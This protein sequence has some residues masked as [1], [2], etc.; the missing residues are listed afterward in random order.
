MIGTG[1]CMLS[2]SIVLFR[3][4]GFLMGAAVDEVEQGLRSVAAAP[5][6]AS[7]SHIDLRKLLS[8]P[9]P[10]QAQGGEL[11]LIRAG[12][13]RF[14]AAVDNVEGLITLAQAALRPLPPLLA[15]QQIAGWIWGIALV[16]REMV[17]LVSFEG[18]AADGCGEG[19]VTDKC[20][21]PAQVSRHGQNIHERSR[22]P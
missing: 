5:D 13:R 9:P 11:L 4:N 20:L 16:E 17:F 8:L 21:T 10:E 1:A 6:C 14:L 12:T 22:Q 19:E 7:C 18:L 2:I 15:G 3:I